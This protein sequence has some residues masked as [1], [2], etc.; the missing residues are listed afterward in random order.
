M[1]STKD[2]EQ[3]KTERM[4]GWMIFFLYKE[5]PLPMELAVLWEVIARRGFPKT[6]RQFA[7]ELDYLCSLGLIRVFPSD[8]DDELDKVR[9]SK[10]IQMYAVTESDDELN[11]TLCARIT[12]DG[13][14]FQHGIKNY[15]GIHRV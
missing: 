6:R 5:R 11:V 7:Q 2:Q 14:N 8:A 13:I 4:R 10:C 3:L 9:Q 12:G 15:E 1:H